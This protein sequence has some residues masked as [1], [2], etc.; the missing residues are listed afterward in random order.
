MLCFK[1]LRCGVV[2]CGVGPGMSGVQLDGT[3]QHSVAQRQQRW[4]WGPR[5]PGGAGQVRWAGW[6]RRPVQDG[7]AHHGACAGLVLGAWCFG[8]LARHSAGCC[9]GPWPPAREEDL[10]QPSGW[11]VRSRERVPTSNGRGGAGPVIVPRAR[12][13]LAYAMLGLG[14]PRR[15]QVRG[16]VPGAHTLAPWPLLLWGLVL[17]GCWGAGLSW[18]VMMWLFAHSSVCC[19]GE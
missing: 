12:R 13:A 14:W 2:C 5:R 3:A 10:H 6:G 18:G 16:I 1:A 8:K 11:D 4:G 9:A 7:T 17:S 19:V 15:Y